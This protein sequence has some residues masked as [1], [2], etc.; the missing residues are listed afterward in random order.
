[1]LHYLTALIASCLFAVSCHFL[2]RAIVYP[3]PE[4]PFERRFSL[5]ALYIEKSFKVCAWGLMSA[6]FFASVLSAFLA[7][8]QEI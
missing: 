1:M 2:I 6:V 4:L 8:F 7:V 3:V 5:S